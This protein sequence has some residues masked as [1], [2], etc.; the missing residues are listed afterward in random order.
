[1]ADPTS[2]SA[3]AASAGITIEIF[4]KSLATIP[5]ADQPFVVDGTELLDRAV[6]ESLFLTRT[7][8]SNEWGCRVLKRPASRQAHRSAEARLDSSMRS[9]NRLTRLKNLA[10]YGIEP[11]VSIANR[12]ARY[13]EIL[14]NT[15]DC[16]SFA[17]N[18]GQVADHSYWGLL[19]FD[20]VD[21]APESCRSVAPALP[22]TGHDYEQHGFRPAVVFSFLLSSQ[23]IDR[24]LRTSPG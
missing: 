6:L 11:I 23:P 10:H 7:S 2:A 24:I 20:L 16:S 3:H 1:M 8:P 14:R 4:S 17:R 5:V 15:R 9:N 21:S 19:P 22:G 18:L 12:E 13:D